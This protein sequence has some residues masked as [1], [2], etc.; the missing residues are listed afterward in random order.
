MD[1]EPRDVTEE[2]MRSRLTLARI[3]DDELE[4]LVDYSASVERML[5][6]ESQNRSETLKR[7]VHTC[8]DDWAYL[9]ERN[10][11][12]SFFI[13]ASLVAMAVTVGE[14]E[15]AKLLRRR[16]LDVPRMLGHKRNLLEENMPIITGNPAWKAFHDLAYLRHKCLHL[17]LNPISE[18][19]WAKLSS[20]LKEAE[21]CLRNGNGE[22][23]LGPRL[24]D[25]AIERL[26]GLMMLVRKDSVWGE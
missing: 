3:V 2:V 7:S 20:E 10:S 22:L 1:H 24:C 12:F 15:I 11:S 19:D 17:G 4:F 25:S 5:V 9:A 18:E 16:G 26:R 13:R 8:G 23:E 6:K 21:I 14:T